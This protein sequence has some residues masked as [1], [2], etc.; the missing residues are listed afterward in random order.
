MSEELGLAA[1]DRWEQLADKFELLAKEEQAQTRPSVCATAASASKT[2]A[3]V[4]EWRLEGSTSD[5]IRERFAL[6]GMKAGLTLG[7]PPG[8]A[9]SLD[10]WL[11]C[12]RQNVSER[13]SGLRSARMAY[14][15]GSCVSIENVCEESVAFCLSLQRQELARQAD[16]RTLPQCCSTWID[17][18][19]STAEPYYYSTPSSVQHWISRV[20]KCAK[21]SIP[22]HFLSAHLNRFL[23][24][25]RVS[26]RTPLRRFFERIAKQHD[27]IWCITHK[28]LWMARHFPI[29]DRYIDSQG[30][31]QPLRSSIL[32]VSPEINLMMGSQAESGN[33]VSTN[34]EK[35]DKFINRVL[36]E[37]G[38]KITRADINLVAG[39]EDMSQFLS[40]QKGQ[41]GKTAATNFNRVLSQPPEVFLKSLQ[42]RKALIKTKSPSN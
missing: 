23:L 15:G 9:N 27:L 42:T 22:I 7:S 4:D 1:V 16:H 8:G 36:E 5:K 11:H 21:V 40:W 29:N 35:I 2:L 18:N 13:A 12:L 28:G 32:A 10:F 34:R 14:E 24:P 31:E 41:S 17:E 25:L 20:A 6:I 37:N 33:H 26:K 19:F 39:Y 3:D 30:I 38:I